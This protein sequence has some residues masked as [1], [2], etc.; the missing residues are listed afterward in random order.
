MGTVSTGASGTYADASIYLKDDGYILDI[1]ISV[2]AIE[3]IGATWPTGVS[4][5]HV[6]FP[7]QS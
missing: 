2:G 1:V 6:V 5:V 3:A 7:S 4:V